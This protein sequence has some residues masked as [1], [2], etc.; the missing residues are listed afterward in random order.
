MLY[1]YIPSPDGQA[2]Q[3]DLLPSCKQLEQAIDGELTIFKVN[4]GDGR[5]EQLIPI[6][7]QDTDSWNEI[8][9]ENHHG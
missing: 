1:L 7:D 8:P 6:D 2:W 9:L 3:S 4:P 5:F